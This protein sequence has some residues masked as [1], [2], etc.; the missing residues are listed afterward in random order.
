MSEPL[1]NLT[2]RVPKKMK[3]DVAEVI[4]RIKKAHGYDVSS[5][6]LY[7]GWIEVGLKKANGTLDK[8][9]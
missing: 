6:S 4:K 5:A 8:E 7:R 3:E 1:E 2:F 9:S